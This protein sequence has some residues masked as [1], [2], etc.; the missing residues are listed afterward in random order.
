[1][2]ETGTQ[3][4]A[5]IYADTANDGDIVL[6]ILSFNNSGT[7]GSVIHAAQEGLSA[8]FPD[9]RCLL[10]NADGGS[11]DG[12]HAVAQGC[13]ADKKDFLQIAYPIDPVQKLSPEYLGVPGK[14]RAIKAVCSVANERNAKVC[15][16]LDS[17]VRSLTQEWIGALAR[18][19]IEGGVDFVSACYPRHKFDGAIFSGIVYPLTRALY[20]KRIQQPMGGEFAFS[21][22]MVRYFLVQPQRDGN[23]LDSGSDIWVTIQAARGGFRMAQAFLGP[24]LLGDSEPVPEVSSILAQTL[25]AIFVEMDRTASVWQRVRGSEKVPT[26]GP[27]GEMATDPIA[28][29]INPMIQSFRLGYQSLQDIWRMVLPPATSMQLK[30]MSFQTAETFQFDDSLWARVVYDFALAWRMRVMD[31][32]HLLKALTPLYLGWVA[33]YIRAVRDA[34]SK[35]TQAA[36]EALCMAFEV[37]KSY[38]ISRWRWPD[39]F[40]P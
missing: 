37:Q 40:N 35:Q 8:Y 2:P 39:R 9:R 26:F 29:D 24:R 14:T 11:K 36:I 1:M 30:R 22:S 15:L 38:F 23:E 32:D 3:Q 19:V 13:V 34:D 12:T 4:D 33:S 10:V 17:N 7:I 16:V 5:E 31:R 20:G 27:C 6:G 18:P 25:G 28:V 21:A